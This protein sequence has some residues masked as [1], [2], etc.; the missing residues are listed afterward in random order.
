LGTNVDGDETL[1]RPLFRP[2][3]L[4]EV[5]SRY[6]APVPR[7]EIQNWTLVLFFLATFAT[8]VGFLFIAHYD[9]RET[10]SGL[11]QPSTG[12][13]SIVSPSPGVVAQVLVKEGDEVDADA[14]LIRMGL[15]PV[16]SD[17]QRLGLALQDATQNQTSALMEE[18]RA[19][20]LALTR[21]RQ[22]LAAQRA[23]LITARSRLV[24]DLELQK[25]RVQLSE[26]SVNAALPLKEKGYFSELQFRQREDAL[27]QAQ[28]ALSAIE[29]K[30]ETATRPS[31]SLPRRTVASSRSPPS[32]LRACETRARPF[33]SGAPAPRPT[34]PS[35]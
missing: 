21:Q 20:T 27:V 11:L 6:G 25:R 13:L 26:L 30:I 16:I 9:R 7:A 3:A 10:V 8:A 19:Q 2:Q 18:S 28:Q 5:G 29:G 32:R 35:F 22:E 1:N 14:P 17:G 33:R 23:Q 31:S 34:R 24:R 12:A 15:D 4:A